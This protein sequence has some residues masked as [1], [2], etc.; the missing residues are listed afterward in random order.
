[1]M[2]K[3]FRPKCHKLAIQL[4]A[5]EEPKPKVKK[6]TKKKNNDENGE[7]IPLETKKKKSTKFSKPN[8][9]VDFDLLSQLPEINLDYNDVPNGSTSVVLEMNSSNIKKPTKETKPK[10]KAASTKKNANVT[11]NPNEIQLKLFQD[12]NFL[13]MTRKTLTRTN[14]GTILISKPP[15]IKNLTKFLSKKESVSIESLS[16]INLSD[17]IQLWQ[18]DEDDFL[19]IG[20]FD[21]STESEKNN[22]SLNETLLL[23]EKFENY[24][25]KLIEGINLSD[26]DDDDVEN[27]SQEESDDLKIE[28]TEIKESSKTESKIKDYEIP[29]TILNDLFREEDDD[30]DVVEPKLPKCDPIQ[31]NKLSKLSELF[32]DEDDDEDDEKLL[33]FVENFRES[34][35]S[36]N[37]TMHVPDTMNFPDNNLYQKKPSLDSNSKRLLKDKTNGLQTI[38]EEIK[39]HESNLKKNK[40]SE[41]YFSGI[42]S[43]VEEDF[44]ENQ[45]I[46]LFLLKQIKNG[47]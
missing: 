39:S 14:T 45:V 27:E 40:Y 2:P 7:N 11:T 36:V 44:K 47:S 28:E 3:G 13:N 4:P 43:D 25:S 20:A 31:I 22:T 41:N 1:M 29:E 12:T 6:G 46:I 15:N 33:N 5:E 30:Y 17:C 21:E 37:V 8:I 23:K 42:F 10:K 26:D 35:K 24:Y 32:C 38:K 16:K 9:N 19:T 18:N 34:S